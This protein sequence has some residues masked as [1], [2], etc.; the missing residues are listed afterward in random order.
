LKKKIIIIKKERNN[1]KIIII[2]Y[3]Y[4]YGTQSVQFI[5]IEHTKKSNIIQFIQLKAKSKEKKHISI[6]KVCSWSWSNA[7]EK[8]A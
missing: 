2:L 7:E 8:D 4:D 3:T 6:R 5:Q 1:N